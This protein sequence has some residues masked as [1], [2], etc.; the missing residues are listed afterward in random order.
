MIS[1]NKPK[2]LRVTTIDGSL[3]TL[4]KGQLRYLNDQ[5]EVVGLANDSGRLDKVGKREGIRTIAV[6]MHREISFLADLWSLWQLI[7]VF[8]REHPQIVHANT[9]KGSLLAM[10]AAWLT[11]VPHRVYTVTGLRFETATGN[12][13]HVLKLMERITCFCA[14]KVIPEGDGVKRTLLREKITSKFLQKIHNGNING[15]DLEYFNRTPEVMAKAKTLCRAGVITF[16]F[17]GRLVRDKGINELAEAFDRLTQERNNV[18][19]MLVGYF[20][21][22]LDPV[23]YTTR[24]IIDK[25]PQIE[26]MGYQLDVRPFLAVSDVLVLPSYREGFPNVLLQAGAMGLP[27]IVT[28]VNGADE[29]INDGKNGLIIPRRD[30]IALYMAMQRLVVDQLLRNQMAADAR[31]VIAKCFD[32][33]DVWQATLE[34]YKSLLR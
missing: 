26:F 4:L 32:Q 23:E 18:R 13:R 7:R 12:F 30:T 9:P 33:K 5:F 24:K 6:P 20:E 14:T 34:M 27:V 2:L 29:V 15:I 10:L 11:R 3:D 8:R 31:S 16:V 22:E 19:L 25:N 17:I 1:G 28:D 21:D